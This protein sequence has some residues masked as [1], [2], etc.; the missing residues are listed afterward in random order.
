MARWIE[1]HAEGLMFAAGWIVEAVCLTALF[2]I[3]A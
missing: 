1:D 2:V 3:I